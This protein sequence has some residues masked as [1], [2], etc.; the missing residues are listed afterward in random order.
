[1]LEE[2]RRRVRDLAGRLG[3]LPLIAR[4]EGVLQ[5]RYRLPAGRIAFDLLRQA[6][7]RH[8]VRLRT[9]A[10]AVVTTPPPVPGAGTW[11]PVRA[12]GAPP[13]LTFMPGAHAAK[14]EQ[15]AVLNAVLGHALDITD[16]DAGNVQLVDPVTGDLRISVYR[17]HSEEF[18]HFFDRVG[19]SGSAC[20]EAS[21]QAVRV[22]ITNVAS[23]PLYTPESRAAM[24]ASGSYACHS[25]P[26]AA[27]GRL[28]GMVSTRF[29]HTITALTTAQARALDDLGEQAGSWL[30]W[31]HR[32]VVM[33]ALEDIHRA[34]GRCR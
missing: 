26:L 30:D 12:R 7:Q 19:E 8:N 33:D 24:L 6:S 29:G 34:A 22:T 2:L 28:R 21:R 20:A 16:S 23:D 13:R 27:P 10:Q 18:V 5:G 14:V 31:H 17:G 3:S 32:T 11:F 9:L 4:A 1:V 15:T 25:I